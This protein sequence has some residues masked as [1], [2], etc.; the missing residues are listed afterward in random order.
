MVEFLSMEGEGT[1][2]VGPPTSVEA[3]TDLRTRRRRQTLHEVHRVAVRLVEEDGYDAT[4]VDRIADASGISQRTFFRYFPAKDDAVLLGYR[5]FAVLI[6]DLVLPAEFSGA[7]GALDALYEQ[8]IAF[9]LDAAADTHSAVQRI[10]CREPKLRDAA[11][12]REFAIGEQLFV[13]LRDAYP[14][15]DE[16]TVRVTMEAASTVFRAARESWRRGSDVSAAELQRLYREARDRFR[17]IVP[18]GG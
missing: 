10:I 16:L 11:I 1:Q 4:T 8:Q 13:R 9:F 6:E 15:V 17:R 5:E 12:A 7:M 2:T 18:A 3:T 14:D